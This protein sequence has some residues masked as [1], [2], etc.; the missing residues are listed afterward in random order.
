MFSAFQVSPSETPYPIT[1]SPVSPPPTHPPTS[2][3][4]PWHSPTL[5]HGTP[6]GPRATPPTYVQQGH[7]LPDMGLEA[8]VP[9]CILFGWWSSFQE[10]QSGGTSGRLTLLLSSWVCKPP[11]LLQSLLQHLH[12]GLC[13]Q[14]HG[15]LQAS[16]SVFVRLW[17]RLSGNSHIRLQSASISQHPQ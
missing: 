17:Q 6:S 2:A 3:F 15:W 5:V 12:W 1:P 13:P 7:P 9:P 4:L 11:Q 10:L 14:S 8:W 16:A